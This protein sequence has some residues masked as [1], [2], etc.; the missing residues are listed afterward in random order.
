LK[1]N[2]YN[3]GIGQAIAIVIITIA[4]S[5]IF[6][7]SIAIFIEIFQESTGELWDFLLGILEHWVKSIG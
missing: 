2:K 6:R 3:F 5:D 7:G 1:F 4:L